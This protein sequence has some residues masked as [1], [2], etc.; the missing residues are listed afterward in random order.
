MN[1]EKSEASVG[2]LFG[3][4]ASDTSYLVRQ[5]L[6]L[7]AAEMTAKARTAARTSGLIAAGA[8]LI[9]LGCVAALVSLLTGLP[10]VLPTLP[11]WATAAI[12]ALVLAGIGATLV[13]MGIRSFRRLDPVPRHT[14]STLR[15][16]GG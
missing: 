7:A 13:Q 4:L 8:A 16:S 9:H 3:S 14:L 15:A 1:S 2:Q 11:M 5:E 10:P 12:V 6:Q